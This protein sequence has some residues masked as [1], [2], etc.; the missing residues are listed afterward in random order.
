MT[1]WWRGGVI[2]QIYPRS[3][4]DS[5]G[6]GIGDLR[7]IT[8]KLGYVASLGVD[9]IWLSPFFTSPM[10]DFGYDIA[11]YCDVDPI[12]GTLADF[13]RL[14]ARAHSLDLKIVVDQVYSH[15]SDKCAWFQESRS[16]RDNPKADWYVWAD[17]KPDGT[18]PNN[19]LAVFGG[20]A[21][22]WEPRRRQYYLH[23]FLPSQPDVNLH[24]PEAQQAMLDVAR[25]WLDRGVDGFRLDVAN[26]Y[27]HD[28][29]L[30][31]N[32]PADLPEPSVKPEYMQ[33]PVYNRSRPETLAFIAR[34]RRLLDRYPERFAVGEIASRQ[35]LKDMVD[36]TD[37]PD[38][39]HTSYSFVFLKEQFGAGYIRG[40]VEEMLA[41]SETAWPSW[42]F[43]NHDV[44]RVVS[45]WANPSPTPDYAKLLIALLTCLR[46]TVFLYQGEELGLPKA[47]V[48]YHRLQDPE[49]R[50]FWPDYESRDNARTPFPWAS[51]RPQGGFSGGQDIEPWLPVEPAHL[52]RALDRQ[53]ADPDSV[54]SFTRRFLDWRKE[55]PALID[56]SIRFVDAPEPLLV[57]VRETD[58]ERIVCA[59]NLGPE[60]IEAELAVDGD[61]AP[62]PEAAPGGKLDPR[63]LD[64]PGHAMAFWDAGRRAG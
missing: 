2:Y 47:N 33:I 38:R 25:F 10:Q 60:P 13:D 7:G 41:A 21:W 37:G 62:A 11:D 18:P 35:Q 16:S 26:F 19:W 54:L 58:E 34:L 14:V 20:P 52:T 55:H 51:D 1:E 36:Y 9:G 23:N 46:G 17:P 50:I 59:F 15:S 31:D 27:T 12:F 3:F 64:L 53:E 48:P 44:M 42:A 45:R 43:S 28:L 29:E 63:T 4:Y 8:E 5:N 32:P 24:N 56:G 39:L 49:G 40:A 57:F 61:W 30:R 22:T 6:D